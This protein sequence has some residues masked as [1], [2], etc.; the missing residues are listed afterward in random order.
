MKT[1]LILAFPNLELYQKENSR[2]SIIQ[3]SLLM[4]NFIFNVI[5][6]QIVVKAEEMMVMNQMSLK[7]FRPGVGLNPFNLSIYPSVLLLIPFKYF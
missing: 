3:R 1:A 7:L 6:S 4:L 2:F 5:K